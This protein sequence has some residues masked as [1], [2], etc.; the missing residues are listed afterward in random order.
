MPSLKQ[1]LIP[2]TLENFDSDFNKDINVVTF[3]GKIRLDM[4]GLT[5]SG[6]II[7]NIWAK[8]IKKHIP[9]EFKPNNILLLGVGGG[10]AAKYLHHRWPQT[11]IIG[12]EID[13]E[14][15]RIAK[16]YFSAD[17]LPNFSIIND[18][19]IN[20]ISK[21]SGDYDIVMVDCYQG[22]QIPKEL[23]NLKLIDRLKSHCKYLLLNRLFWDDYQKHTLRFISSLKTKFRISTC[24]TP[25]NLVLSVQ[26]GR[27]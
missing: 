2:I 22:D 18:D 26:G 7:E 19:A 12:V 6:D 24:R 10:S 25:S 16:Q 20:F 17:D 3:L 21:I 9:P 4:G 14:V 5:Q 27:V 23:E 13:P 1:Y 11:N 8:A 15:I